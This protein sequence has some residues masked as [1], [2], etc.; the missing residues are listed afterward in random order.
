ML[1]DTDLPVKLVD[2]GVIFK[3]KSKIICVVA[4]LHIGYEYFLK[5]KGIIVTGLTYRIYSRLENLITKENVDILYIAG[6]VKHNIAGISWQE[7][8]DIPAIFEK[9]VN[10]CEITVIPGNHDGNIR[11]LLPDDVRITHT[12]GV[13]LMGRENKIRY[14]ILHGHT[15]PDNNLLS[16]DIIISGHLHPV[17]SIINTQGCPETVGCYVV[18]IYSKSIVLPAFNDFMQGHRI[19][20][21]SDIAERSP[22]LKNLK[23]C[24][25]KSSFY[26]TD[27]AFLGNILQNQV[28]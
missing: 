9:L 13:V 18:N 28:C 12:K 26:L 5:K 15:V 20:R 16:S 7:F 21:F 19:N 22:L 11:K 6:D 25:E 24:L 14:G 4:D 2:Y 1:S 3:I 17:I 23:F 8:R 27:G 10:L